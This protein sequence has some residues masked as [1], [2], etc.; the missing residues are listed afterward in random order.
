MKRIIIWML[1][2][3]ICAAPAMGESMLKIAIPGYE[4]D[5]IDYSLAIMQ[6]GAQA[7]VVWDEYEVSEFD[8]LLLP[9]GLDIHPSHYGQQDTACGLTDTALDEVQFSAADAFIKAGKPVLGICRGHQLLN[10][11]FGGSLIQDIETAPKHM[12]IDDQDNVHST[13]A[14]DY[15]AALYGEMPTVNS[16]HHQAVDELGKGLLAV[17]WAQDSTV[18]AM[19]HESLPVISVQWHPERMCFAYAREDTVDGSAVLRY[20]LD[21]CQEKDEAF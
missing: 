16:S 21:M 1:T 12:K 15:I 9:G 5:V 4:A 6:L 8:G 3:L 20:F 11:Y 13:V 7:V 19:R 18:E 17:Q 14:E 2:L 10:V